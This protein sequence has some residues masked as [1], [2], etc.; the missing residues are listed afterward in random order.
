VILY[1]LLFLFAAVLAFSLYKV[2]TVSSQLDREQSQFEQLAA[3]VAEASAAPEAE[4]P[5]Q[6][7]ESGDQAAAAV[8]R[9]IMPQYLPLYAQNQDFFGWL[10]IEGT[11]VNYPVMY[12]PEDP[13]YYL[14]RAFDG[15]YSQSGTPF[16]DGACPAEGVHYLIHGH[17]MKNGTMFG[18]LPEYAQRAYWEEHPVI[19]FDTLYEQREY[20]VIAA[21][22]SR[23]YSDDEPGVFRYY[24]Y[25]DLS[26]PAVFA[27]YIAGVSAAAIYDTGEKAEYGDE[28]I[29][30]S[31][32]NYHT[33]DGR[34]V[35][36]A[37][38]IK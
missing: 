37:R 5:A 28:L 35:V 14:H 2:T 24:R 8:E 10:R 26:D 38:R 25:T 12:T 30:L 7:K 9:R 18:V 6:D 19:C 20:T 29:T 1:I 34:F 11:E 17:H 27:E 16:I 22:Y 4:P 3:I 21:F 32:C 36:V 31:T 15:E 23:L 33:E 13:E